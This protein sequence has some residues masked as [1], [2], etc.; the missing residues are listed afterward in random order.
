LVSDSFVFFADI[1][2][3]F[4]KMLAR[5]NVLDEKKAALPSSFVAR[6]GA[7][8]LPTPPVNNEDI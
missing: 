3:N 5:K 8:V 6:T 7:N 4:K 2:M 1:M